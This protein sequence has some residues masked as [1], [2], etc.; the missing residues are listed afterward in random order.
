MDI[1]LA[2]GSKSVQATRKVFM[3]SL[4]FRTEIAHALKRIA[5]IEKHLGTDTK[6]AA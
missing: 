1:P 6:I 2:T 5:L 3:A 4:G